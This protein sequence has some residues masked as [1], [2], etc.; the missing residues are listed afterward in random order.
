MQ[1]ALFCYQLNSC[2]LDGFW[3]EP[4]VVAVISFLL[5][6]FPFPQGNVQGNML[7]CSHMFTT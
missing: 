2:S 3:K 4:D 7:V 6:N 1:R 5:E